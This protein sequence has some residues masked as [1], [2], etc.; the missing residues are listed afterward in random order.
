MATTTGIGIQRQ[1]NGI[2]FG[3]MPNRKTAQRV[4]T[5]LRGLSNRVNTTKI[6]V[7]ALR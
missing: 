7:D 2:H 3:S 1:R 4:R 5:L 6:A